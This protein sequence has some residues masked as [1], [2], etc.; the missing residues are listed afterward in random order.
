MQLSLKLAFHERGA[1]AVSAVQSNTGPGVCAGLEL[2][3]DHVLATIPEIRPLS[4]TVPESVTEV[5]KWLGSHTKPAG[6][7]HGTSQPLSGNTLKRRVSV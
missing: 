3:N 5:T 2:G 6:N 1:T 7:G 4:K